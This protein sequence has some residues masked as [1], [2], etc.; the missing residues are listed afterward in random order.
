MDGPAFVRCGETSIA[1]DRLGDGGTIALL[2]QPFWLGIDDVRAD[3]TTFCP[4]LSAGHQVIVHDRRGTG[5]SD[6]RPGQIGVK[7]QADD[8]AAILDDIGVSRVLL[9]AMSEAAPLAVH[10]AAGHAE[11]VARLVL[12]DPQLRPRVGPGSTMLLHTLHSRPRVGLKAFARSLVSDDAA[13][14]ALAA[15]MSERMDAPTAARLYEAFLQADAL[16]VAGSVEARTLLAFGVHD[17]MVVEEEARALQGHF[18]NA[19]IGLV[20]G[21]P[22]TAE[23]LREAWVQVHDFLL[24]PGLPDAS[25]ESVPL[26]RSAAPTA[27]PEQPAAG[28]DDYVPAGPPP[29]ARL[30]MATPGA[31]AAQRP[32]YTRWRPSAQV[33]REAVELNRKAIDHILLGEIEA[34]LVLFQQAVE[35]APAYEDAQVNYRELLSR[36]VQRRVAQWQNEQA[37]LVLAEAER[38]ADRYAKRTRRS[39]LPRI[40]RPKQGAA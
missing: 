12:V 7:V 13:A 30:H 20:Q 21:T 35:I 24:Q 31:S 38:R 15:R 27:P 40:L 33:P 17:R 29:A 22:G 32:A 28:I 19:Q 23:A 18:A 37:E 39:K 9:V 3:A 4:Q 25:A 10:F 8:L 26:R 5:A 14:E 6:R 16:T 11:R 34:A 36:L 1:Y 2:L